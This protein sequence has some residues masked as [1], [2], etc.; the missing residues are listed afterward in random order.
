VALADGLGDPRRRLAE[1]AL[2]LD[3]LSA[4][5]RRGLEH[6]VVWERRELTGL[7]GRLGRSGP[8][9]RLRA[10][11]ERIS[12]LAERL[13]FALG[14]RVR[15]ARAGLEQGASKLDVLSPLACLARGYSIVRRDDA[16]GPLVRDAATLV[17]GDTVALL[18]SRGRARARIDET[19][20]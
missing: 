5:A 2:H 4:R 9:A 19:D 13:R 12:A 10:G 14:V 1:A 11:R 3:E 18:F 20:V 15:H 7:A 8:D 16:H 6:R 17:A